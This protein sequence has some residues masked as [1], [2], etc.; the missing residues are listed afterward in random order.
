MVDGHRLY[1]MVGDV[2]GKGVPASLFMA[3]SKALCKS[4]VLRQGGTVADLMSVANAEI[5]R[6]NP[7]F[8]F[9]TAVAGILDTDTGALEYCNAGHDAPLVVDGAGNVRALDSMGGPPICV[10]DDFDYPVDHATLAPGELLL[11]YTDGVGEA[12]RVDEAMYGSERVE[13]FMKWV[14]PK[15]SDRH[16][17]ESLFREVKAFV[18]GNEPNDDITILA[19]RYRDT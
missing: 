10:M 7:A 8:M 4:A 9:V 12:M 15:D 13:T 1:F 18:D 11:L 19:L 6:E 5:S 14:A 2:S 17:V 3:L 16:T